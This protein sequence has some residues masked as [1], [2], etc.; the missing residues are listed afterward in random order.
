MSWVGVVIGL[1]L[2]GE[3]MLFEDSISSLHSSCAAGDSGTA[4]DNVVDADFEVVDDEKE[5]K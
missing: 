4:D 5:D 2:D 1:P 3:K